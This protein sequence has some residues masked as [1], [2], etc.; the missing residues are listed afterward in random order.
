MGLG[1]REL[2]FVVLEG[3][4]NYEEDQALISTINNWQ[5][6]FIALRLSSSSLQWRETNWR[7]LKG[8]KRRKKK[9]T[10]T[11]FHTTQNKK[12]FLTTQEK[13]NREKVRGSFGK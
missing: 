12:I 4:N 3:T 8:T 2:M 6:D 10:D 1:M 9:K 7:K 11:S 13:K 5:K